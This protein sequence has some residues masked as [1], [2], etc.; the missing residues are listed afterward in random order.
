MVIVAAY[1]CLSQFLKERPMEL[2]LGLVIVV[3]VIS[4]C[5]ELG[6]KIFPNGDTEN[7]GFTLTVIVL[8][9]LLPLALVLLSQ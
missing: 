4:I 9:V 3:I 7:S 5:V 1:T 6:P 2:L 8:F